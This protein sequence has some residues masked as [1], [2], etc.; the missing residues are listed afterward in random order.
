MSVIVRQYFCSETEPSQ[1]LKEIGIR[2]SYCSAAVNSD[3]LLAH[4][5]SRRK[6][7]YNPVVAV[8]VSDVASAENSCPHYY[9][10]V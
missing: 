9:K 3:R 5:G 4:Q 8:S 1:H 10:S 7:H 6:H 2:L